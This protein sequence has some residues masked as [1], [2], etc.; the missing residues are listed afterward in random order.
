MCGSSHGFKAS[1]SECTTDM[2]TS[3][4]SPQSI[5]ATPEAM[6]G[7]QDV[8]MRSWSEADFEEKS[9]YF[10]K[11]QPLEEESKS[12]GKLRAERSLPRN[13]ALKR[14]HSSTE[15][16]PYNLIPYVEFLQKHG[17]TVKSPKTSKTSKHKRSSCLCFYRLSL[18]HS[19]ILPST[20]PSS[21]GK[22]LTCCCL[23]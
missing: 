19:N 6:T 11:D 14:S 15:V 9:T 7:T 12:R 4:R 22:Y 17:T 13:L 20:H 3:E 21:G 10:V 1:S 18:R 16:R 23:I 8:D 5:G 2:L